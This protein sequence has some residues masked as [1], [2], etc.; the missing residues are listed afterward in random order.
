MRRNAI[1]TIFV[2]YST[3]II[4]LGYNNHLD[5]FVRENIGSN[6]IKMFT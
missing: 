6:E 2:M 1:R 4:K 3:T 5:T